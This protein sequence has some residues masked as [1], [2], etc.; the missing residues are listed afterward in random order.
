MIYA[1]GAF[2]GFHLGHR[3]LLERAA[4]RAAEGG[5]GWGVMTF[6]GHPRMLLN[7]GDFKMLFSPEERGVI[8]RSL[9]VPRMERIPFTREFASLS[10]EGFAGFIA[11]RYG[12]DGLVVGENFRFAKNRAGDPRVLAEL[13]AERGWSLDVMPS[14]R[15]GGCV[16]SSTETRIAVSCGQMRRA[17][18]L[19]GYP[20]MISGE[21]SHGDERGRKIGFR[22]AN[23]AMRKN[24]VYPPF[25]VYAA[26]VSIDGGWLAA[27]LNVGD[28]PTFGGDAEPRCEAHILDYG[29]ALYGK[30]LTLFIVSEIRGEIKFASAHEL[31]EQISH[32]AAECS[33]ACRGYLSRNEAAMRKF[34]ALL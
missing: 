10:P 34:A 29:G 8:A 2:D 17:A 31:A 30:T 5:A 22:T 20:F 28:N 6:E 24:K 18:E 4:R 15:I 3:R 13:S 26:L 1:L 9:G 16:V 27:A 21:V 11:E 14:Y 25:G 7:G 23:I 12:I 19:L 33:I 32:D